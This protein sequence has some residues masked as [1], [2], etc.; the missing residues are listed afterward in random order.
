M[1]KRSLVLW[2]VNAMLILSTLGCVLTPPPP[3][4]SMME[5]S[6]TEL[7]DPNRP[8][9]VLYFPNEK[10]FMKR[11]G[12][13]FLTKYPGLSIEVISLHDFYIRARTDDM[14]QLDQHFRE[15]LDRTKPDIIS[16]LNLN[17]L[18][19]NNRLT[20]LEPYIKNAPGV[21]LD[22]MNP[23]VLSE[24][25][26]AGEGKLYALSP[27]FAASVLY[28]NKT[29]FDKYNLPYPTVDSTWTEVLQLANRFP[30][31]NLQGEKIY[32]LLYEGITPFDLLQRISARH[33]LLFTDSIGRRVDIQTEPWIRL[34]SAIL[35]GHQNENFL[36][37]PMGHPTENPLIK[38]FQDGKAAMI[39]ETVNTFKIMEHA[40]SPPLFEWD[41]VSEP[42][43]PSAVYDGEIRINNPF[44]I[45]VQSDRKEDAWK[46]ISFIAG[47]ELARQNM[48]SDVFSGLS[49][50]EEHN[51]PTTKNIKA[52]YE[53]TRQKPS[54]YKHPDEF[55]MIFSTLFEESFNEAVKNGEN[56]EAL[57]GKLQVKSQMELERLLKN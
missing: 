45:H 27:S 22:K 30:P 20:D 19:K 3:P 29:M 55:Q 13:L 32:S 21:R 16:G 10:E 14:E 8:L 17:F 11:Y 42:G 12:N 26:S 48:V 49:V 52:F 2:V 24:L 7:P 5:Q 6:M 4:S 47:E 39:F 43:D 33:N 50:Y 23:N 34:T 44:S 35:T 28:Y 18:I 54:V 57:L 53:T 46:F 31:Q 51:R 1:L 37:G 25:R 9:R 36:F 40:S 15:F 56:A 41:I 38:H